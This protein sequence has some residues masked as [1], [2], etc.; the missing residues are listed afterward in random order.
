MSAERTSQTISVRK[1]AGAGLLLAGAVVMLAYLGL[2]GFQFKAFLSGSPMDLLGSCPGLGLAS[3][4]VVQSVAFDH[5]AL[6]S[7]AR[8]ILVLCSA[9]AAIVVGLG[10]LRNRAGRRTASN[11]RHKPEAIKGDE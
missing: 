10:M 2:L 5:A 9:F 3:L 11:R 4:R 6:F 7:V 1:I 8:K